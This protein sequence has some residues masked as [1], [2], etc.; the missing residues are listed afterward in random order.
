MKGVSFDQ[1]MAER[2]KMKQRRDD[3]EKNLILH[4][5]ALQTLDQLIAMAEKSAEEKPAKE[6]G[7]AAIVN[8]GVVETP[9]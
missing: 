6:A 8:N 4:D 7:A 9:A 2:A 3:L 1:L 5:G